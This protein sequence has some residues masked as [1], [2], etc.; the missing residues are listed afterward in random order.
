MTAKGSAP[1]AAERFDRAYYDK[2]YESTTT[3]VHGP[4]EIAAL[5]T[6]VV[7][8]MEWY[9]APLR[10]VLD[11]GAGPGLWRDWF[12]RE[13][14]KVRYRSVEYSTYACER[15]HH[16]HGDLA[17]LKG[18]E[19]YDLVVCQ[20]VLPYVSDE[21][22]PKAMGKLAKFASGFLYLECVTSRDL[23]TVCDQEL[24]D[25]HIHRRSGDVY[26]AHLD[27][28]F[29]PVGAG[30][31]YAKSGPCVFYELETPAVFRASKKSATGAKTRDSAS[32]PMNKSA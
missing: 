27:R 10:N 21:D 3:R 24:T 9:G 29:V 19:R 6:G 16:E 18:S 15:Y 13:K 11:V 20:G 2:H 17:T 26:R 5:C 25:T 7:G 4:K 12:K 30:L 14:P 1:N 23:R 8:M 28:H 32:R 31:Y 22:L